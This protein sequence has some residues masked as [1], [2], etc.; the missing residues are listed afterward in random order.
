MFEIFDNNN[1]KVSDSTKS[2]RWRSSLSRNKPEWRA[3]DKAVRGSVTFGGQFPSR[4][5]SLDL[6]SQK[7]D[8]AIPGLYA[9]VIP[10]AGGKTTLCNKF[11]QLDIDCILDDETEDDIRLLR[12]EALSAQDTRKAKNKWHLHNEMW[13][14]S[15]RQALSRV[16]WKSNP[17]V[18]F[19]HT[20]EVARCCGAS[21]LGI[22]VPEDAVQEANLLDGGRDAV[23]RELAR[24]NKAEVLARSGRSPLF[25]TYSTREDLAEMVANMISQVTTAPGVYGV[26][27]RRG[28][29]RYAPFRQQ[30]APTVPDD[31]LEEDWGAHHI[32]Q[33][34]RLVNRQ[35]V[36]RWMIGSWL[37]CTDLQVTVMGVRA[38]GEY[39]WVKLASMI[40]PQPARDLPS[41]MFTPDFDWFKAYPFSHPTY[42]A[43]SNVRLRDLF[44]NG[45]AS[46]DTA[47][48]YAR[49]LLSVHMGAEH[50]FVVSILVYWLGVV[51]RMRSLL[52]R[53]V[54]DSGMLEVPESKWIKIHKEIHNLVRNTHT[55]FGL[56]VSYDEGTRLQYTPSLYGRR[57]YNIDVE[58]EVKKRGVERITEKM[59]Y[60]NG[61]SNEQYW[62]D[63]KHA[64]RAAYS[65]LGN[66]S[67]PRWRNTEGFFKDRYYWAAA[68]AVTNL[69]DGLRYLK[70]P[71]D[72]ILQLKDGLRRLKAD[73][74]KKILMEK[75]KH[76]AELTDMLYEYWG[77]NTTRTAPKPNEPAK[78]RVLIPGSFLHY[79]GTTFLLGIIEKTGDV[80]AVRLGEPDDIN[81]YHYDIFLA[82]TYYTFM[83]DFTDHNSQ[84]SVA[85]MKFI[86]EAM[87]TP[88]AGMGVNMEDM[89]W[90]ANW[91]LDSF[92]NM[93]LIDKDGKE[94]LLQSGLFTGWRST[95]WI[96]S[97]AC[98]AYVS[99][100]L[101]MARRMYGHIGIQHFEG[102]GDD[103]AMT[104]TSMLDALRVHNCMKMA[105]FEMNDEKQ[106]FEYELVEFLRITV[107]SKQILSC[108]N[109]MLPNFICGDLERSNPDFQSR[110]AGGYA[111]CSAL[112]RRGLDPKMAQIIFTA[113][114]KKWM[115]VKDGASYMQLPTYLI[116]G[117]AEDGGMGV[118][119]EN[120]CTWRLNI[121]MGLL[122][123]VEIVRLR[124]V[125]NATEDALDK[126]EKEVRTLGATQFDRVAAKQSMLQ[127]VYNAAMRV[128]SDEAVV[129]SVRQLLTR[130]VKVL[131][132]VK[133]AP[134]IDLKLL[135][136]VF[137]DNTTKDTD[138]INTALTRFLALKA[139][140]TFTDINMEAIASQ[141]QLEASRALM[142]IDLKFPML[143]AFCVPEYALHT[144]TRVLKK[145]V[146]TGEA[147]YNQYKPVFACLCATYNVAF[148]NYI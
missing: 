116:H 56:P 113:F 37:R 124:G 21:L 8:G 26:I 36:P 141:C 5:G 106:S 28:C 101:M 87:L 24:M 91:V 82:N 27:G 51:A 138:K 55:F 66:K 11:A 13:Y 144:I 137:R 46:G 140:V 64:V 147:T 114:L 17:K 58:P 6:V 20:E 12:M 134:S 119:D 31:I 148:N 68:G 142:A 52:V 78:E 72:V 71:L 25:K 35:Q 43:Q 16:Y 127:D 2:A 1:L 117:D 44:K 77:Y 45:L 99:V 69:P 105:G 93:C 40:K 83:L 3:E 65:N 135:E 118:P 120:G 126:W 38:G 107:K 9:I 79:V 84:H 125:S 42:V 67:K 108:V 57:L 92:D 136:R 74:N 7:P 80:G 61:L 94:R 146:Y 89:R 81:I 29:S 131:C 130:D 23:D 22:L 75:L 102:A 129:E 62:I 85:E 63:F 95:T 50:S 139:K 59:S 54:V 132:R 111:T 60:A 32:D 96:N 115:R 10:S 90:F 121:K 48:N 86:M 104:F 15:C 73:V 128:M 14:R 122:S 76:P 34:A 39:D 98:Q 109:R 123:K 100:G 103:V 33:I 70:E 133:D 47:S 88:I 19:C 41:D 30:F 97:V 110:A 145:W 18:L 112:V 143:Y 4:R 49:R 53:Q